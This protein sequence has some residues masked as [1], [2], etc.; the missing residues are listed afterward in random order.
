MSLKV[1]TRTVIIAAATLF[2]G[3]AGF[4][5]TN[6]EPSE[7]QLKQSPLPRLISVELLGTTKEITG[8]TVP[9]HILTGKRPGF[10]QVDEP[11]VVTVT[12]PGVRV[13]TIPVK[14]AFVNTEID[15][16]TKSAIVVDIDLLPLPKG[17][18]FR[19]AV[20]E[21]RRL[22]R[23]MKIEPDELMRKQMSTWPDDSGY[24]IYR[25]GV[26]LN[27]SVKFMVD[28]RPTPG[29]DGFYLVLTFSALGDARRVLWDAT[30]KPAANGPS[31]SAGVSKK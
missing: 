6:D 29:N 19:E 16:K 2:L 5:M 22:L 11:S 7:N 23:D 4:S 25:T 3:W 27:E 24:H 28:V 20:A 26:N 10:F 12:L 14:T 15:V 13:V 18:P 31:S 17:L 30:F 21:F 9:A 8:V 1:T